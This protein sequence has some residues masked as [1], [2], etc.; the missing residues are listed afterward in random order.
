M[1]KFSVTSGLQIAF[2]TE[3]IWISFNAFSEV[4][5]LNKADK[6]LSEGGSILADSR[7]KFLKLTIL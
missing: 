2:V 4:S 1:F 7:I 3:R 6:K 5:V